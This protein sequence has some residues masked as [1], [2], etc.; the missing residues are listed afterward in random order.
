MTQF[1]VIA[2]TTAAIS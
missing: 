2:K 1:D